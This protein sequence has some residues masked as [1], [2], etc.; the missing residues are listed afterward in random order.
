MNK[1]FK[2]LTNISNIIIVFCLSTMSI[3]VFTNVILRYIFS[4]GMTWAEELS[5]YLFV[6]LIFLG[7]I[8]ALKQNAHMSVDIVTN[9]VSLKIRKVILLINNL[10]VLFVM[11][12][13]LDGSWKMTLQNM[14]IQS[15]SLGI[16]MFLIYGV[17]IVMSISM[18]V[19]V[20]GNIVRLFTNEESKE[21]ITNEESMQ[22]SK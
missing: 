10:L 4:S 19:I 5:R 8:M 21:H 18:A 2:I 13:I 14:N 9:A 6:W 7:A 16:P 11:W 22:I 12:M 17:G 1:I 3:L 20:I 15:P